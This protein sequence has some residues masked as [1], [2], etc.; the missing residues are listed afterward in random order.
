MFA[1]RRAIFAAVV[2]ALALCR[3]QAANLYPYRDSDASASPRISRL[4]N[5]IESG[6]ISAVEEFWAQMRKNGTPLVEP[7]PGDDRHSLVTFLWSASAGTRNVAI[8][9]G[10]NGAE[11]ARNQMTHLVDTDV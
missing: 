6:K 4:R 8:V 7:V 2:G 9:N 11:P 1:V 3:A 10:I 5:D